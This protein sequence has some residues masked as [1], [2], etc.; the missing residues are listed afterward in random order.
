MVPH[1]L[2][3]SFF[4]SCVCVCVCGACVVRVWCVCGCVGGTCVGARVWQQAHLWP[5][6]GTP[7]TPAEDQCGVCGAVAVTVWAWRFGCTHPPPHTRT[8]THTHPGEHHATTRTPLHPATRG[9][10][11]HAAVGAGVGVRRRQPSPAQPSPAQCGGC[12]THSAAA[13]VCGSTAWSTAWA[14]CAA[15][16]AAVAVSTP[17]HSHALKHPHFHTL[18]VPHTASPRTP[19]HTHRP[20]T[21]SPRTPP[22]HPHFHTVC[23]RQCRKAPE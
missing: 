1:L 11:A 19:P 21:A 23:R 8:H 22:T 12:T 10:S 7:A 18:G 4:S 15:W 20:H 5:P 14:S 6:P 17:T 16:A 2:T 13:S 9:L 3:T